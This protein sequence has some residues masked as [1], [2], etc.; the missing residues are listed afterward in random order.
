MY[1]HRVYIV[2]MSCLCR[3]YVAFEVQVKHIYYTHE[4]GIQGRKH[5]PDTQIF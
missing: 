1:L 4:A 3:V 2:Y 5:N